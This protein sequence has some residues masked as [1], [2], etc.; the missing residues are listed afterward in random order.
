MRLSCLDRSHRGVAR[1]M[2]RLLD[3]PGSA[4]PDVVR[5]LLYRPAFFGGPLSAALNPVMRRRRSPWSR[6]ERELFAAYTSR[7]NQC[8]F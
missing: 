5:A 2:L 7:L 8:P 1:L 4:V 3:R 6:G